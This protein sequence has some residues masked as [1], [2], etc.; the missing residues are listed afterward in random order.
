MSFLKRKRERELLSKELSGLITWSTE[1]SETTRRKIWYLFVE[2]S[3][4]NLVILEQARYLTLKSEG[5]TELWKSNLNPIEDL[6][7]FVIHSESDD[8]PE[9][10]ERFYEVISEQKVKI[11][12]GLWNQD[13]NFASEVERIFLEDRINWIFDSGMVLPRDLIFTHEHILK[14]T[15]N[16]L[17]NPKYADV[18]LVFAKG[19]KEISVGDPGDAIT[20]F[21]TAIQV[22]L[23][24]LGCEGKT[25]GELT[26]S[27]I[28]KGILDREDQK[29]LEAIAMLRNRGEAHD[30][31]TYTSKDAWFAC[32]LISTLMLKFE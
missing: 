28:S 26:I 31:E 22:F 8:F 21:G 16:Y 13:A 20:D 5:W 23:K 3:K 1:F 17:N 29:I 19:L 6:Y 9:A 2:M 27:G 14:P 10:I 24:V 12:F 4:N 18:K 15:L 7:H 32:R 11:D 25:I 30:L